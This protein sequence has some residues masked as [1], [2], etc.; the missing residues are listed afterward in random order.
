MKRKLAVFIAACTL[1]LAACAGLAASDPV[2]P[3]N[4]AGVQET[5]VEPQYGEKTIAAEEWFY[6]E[7]GEEL[8]HYQY[9]LPAIFLS[10]V[11]VLSAE[12]AEKAGQAVDTYNTMMESL[13]ED[14]RERGT[15]IYAAALEIYQTGTLTEPYY[16]T[17]YSGGW[18]AGDILS[19]C[20]VA[21][22]YTGG[23]HPNSYHRSYLFDLESG[24][25]IDL[26]QLADD[27]EMFRTGVEELLLEK[28]E[29]D[30]QRENFWEDYAGVIARWNEAGL[31]FDELGLSVIF[32][33]YE[34]GPYSCG[35][36]TLR[37]SWEELEPLLGPG[38]MERLGLVEAE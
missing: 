11:D 2:P 22:T 8:A 12:E 37:L 5:H 9:T 19:N 6:T 13:L 34:L 24:Q 17:V 21:Y 28:A 33:P 29:K 25:F 30:G 4:R 23:A 3:A 10:N 18:E 7:N 38:G 32:S 35:E 1:L 15:A 14:Y 36:I 31:E 16:D 20:M 26:T 27:P